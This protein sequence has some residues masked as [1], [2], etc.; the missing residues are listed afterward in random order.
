[1]MTDKNWHRRYRPLE[2][3]ITLGDAMW[4]ADG[5]AT[6]A[7]PSGSTRPKPSIILPSTTP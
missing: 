1:M 3:A 5:S 4:L 2:A 6:I 7:S